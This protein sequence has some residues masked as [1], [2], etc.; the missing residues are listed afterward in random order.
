MTLR[1][2][3]AIF[4]LLSVF[5]GPAESAFSFTDVLNGFGNDVTSIFNKLIKQV[6]NDASLNPNNPKIKE[7]ISYFING[8]KN[9]LDEATSAINGLFNGA[10][11]Q[12]K[13]AMKG[14][15]V[16]LFFL[17]DIKIYTLYSC[18]HLTELK[19]SH[20]LPPILQRFVDSFK[21]TCMTKGF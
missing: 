3:L 7:A 2:V 4:V 9:T 8:T 1:Q 20:I 11:D 6:D 17:H 12:I 14:M 10:G 13:R 19:R 18:T 15:Y 21:N 5:S 16:S